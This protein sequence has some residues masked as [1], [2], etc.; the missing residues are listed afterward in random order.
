MICEGYDEMQN[1]LFNRYEQQK[2]R[3]P[4]DSN[5]SLGLY[6][7]LSQKRR[8]LEHVVVNS[9]ATATRNTVRHLSLLRERIES[10]PSSSSS[11][12]ETCAL[13]VCRE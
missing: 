7:P 3:E 13:C 1:H 10:N 9:E 12:I 8:L 4:I 11:L 2:T 6:N 5:H